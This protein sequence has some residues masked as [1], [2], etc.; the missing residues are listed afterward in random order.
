MPKAGARRRKKHTH[1]HD[2]PNP[3]QAERRQRGGGGDGG[4]GGKEG[5]IATSGR[6]PRSMVIRRGKNTAHLKDLQADLRKVRLFPVECR[7]Q[8]EDVSQP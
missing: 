7:V 1:V 4:G 2:G 3:L 6:V 8:S 5:A